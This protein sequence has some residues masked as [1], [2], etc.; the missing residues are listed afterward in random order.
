[1]APIVRALQA[2][3]ALSFKI[4]PCVAIRENTER[5]VTVDEG[6]NVL[7]GTD[8]VRILAETR[9]VLRGVGKQGKR[10]HKASRDEQ[11]RKIID[12]CAGQRGRHADGVGRAPDVPALFYR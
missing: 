1:M 3:H 2:Q 9:K 10:L 7:V 4:V 6:S 12:D 8:P 11:L 5:P